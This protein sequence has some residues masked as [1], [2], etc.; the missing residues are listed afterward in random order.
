MRGA[1]GAA[2]LWLSATAAA[3]T[4]DSASREA[5]QADIEHYRPR[6]SEVALS[7]WSAA[8]VGYQEQRSSAALQNELRDAGFQVE[9]GVAGMPTA[10]VARAGSG[11]PVIALLAEYDALPGLSQAAVAHRQP[12]PGQTAGHA[13]GH[14]LFG[15]ASIGAAIALK[16]WLERSGTP[17]EVRVYGS[18]AEEG[19]AGKVYLVRAGLFDDVDVALHWHPSD[20]NSAAQWRSLANISGKFR[21]HGQS[22]HAAAAPEAGRSALDAVE[23]M[24]F[25]ANLMREHVSPE[26]RIHYII[27][28][29]G[30]APNVV[31][32][33]AEVYY[34]ARHPQPAETRSVFERLRQAAEGAAL[35]TGTRYELEVTGGVYSLLPNDTLGRVMDASLRSVGAPVWT[36]QETEFARELGATLGERARPTAEAQGIARYGIESVSASSTDVGD[37]SWT[38]PTAGFGV[39]TWPPGTPSHSWQAVAAGGTGLGLKGMIVAAKTL[40]LAAA[41]LYRN[42]P[43]I[44]RAKAEFLRA[45]GEIFD[46]R[47]MLGDRDPPLDYRDSTP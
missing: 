29:G 6:L 40:S 16:H 35:G 25:M 30:S 31:P 20:R 8:E 39:A 45:R 5:L 21:F 44:A 47:P 32:D 10:F 34:Y 13:C 36:P 24:N 42:P 33:F 27:S 11:G 41:T 43:L 22:A 7:L 17:G 2:L 12:L 18:P 14:H 1:L 9:S 37:I 19:G 3:Q 26:T 28:H 15:T 46:Y 4:L 38:V 23:A